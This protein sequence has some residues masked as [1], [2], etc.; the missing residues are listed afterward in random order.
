[1]I[2]RKYSHILIML[3]ALSVW[4]CGS[5]NVT[6]NLTA[7]D[8]F[9][10]GKKKFVDGDYLEAVNEFEIVRL[11][12]PGSGVADKAQFFLAECHYKMDEYLLA[13]EDYQTLKRNMPASSYVPLAQ[14][15]IAMCYYSLSPGSSLDQIYTKRAIDE[16]QAFIEYNPTHEFVHDAE[17]KIKELNTRL[18]KKL[19]DSAELYVKMEYYKAATIYYGYVV[20]K[21]HDTKYAE[22]ALL[23]KVKALIARKRFGEA[24]PEIEH[25]LEKYPNSEHKKEAE[26]LRRE[27]DDHIKTHS[28]IISYRNTVQISS[29]SPIESGVR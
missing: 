19:Y 29:L 18:A 6:Q 16:F 1:M 20:E 5:S 8:R 26:S 24:K 9:E 2:E 7:E 23:G 10:L 25:Y 21:Y 4:S 13:A 12:F 17:E 27:I 3:F 14:Y 15:K 11:Q 28:G 22:P